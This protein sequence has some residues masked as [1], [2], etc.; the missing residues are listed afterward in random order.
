MNFEMKFL[1]KI[2]QQKPDCQTELA[3]V[4]ISKHGIFSSDSIGNKVITT[5]K[6]GFY[7]VAYKKRIK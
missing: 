3:E 6:G 7:L 4:G 5:M 1:T 2:Y